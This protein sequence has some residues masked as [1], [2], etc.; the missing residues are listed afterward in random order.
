MSG[1]AFRVV[2]VLAILAGTALVP[3]KAHADGDGGGTVTGEVTRAASAAFGAGGHVGATP[4]EQGTPASPYETAVVPEGSIG[5][6]L[7]G[8][9]A[10][11]CD[12]FGGGRVTRPEPVH[13]LSLQQLEALRNG[14]LACE[15]IDSMGDRQRE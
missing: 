11:Y 15:Y 7:T 14:S 10:R 5:S 8:P 13:S 1:L 2:A 9:R 6:L 12:P 3:W 4:I